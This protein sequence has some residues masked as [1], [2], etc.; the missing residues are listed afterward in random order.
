MPALIAS[1]AFASAGRSSPPRSASAVSQAR[2]PGSGD[3]V[4]KVFSRGNSLASASTTRLIRK[5][6]KLIPTRP[7]WQF[8]IE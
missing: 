1:A 4:A 8:E 3:N 5:S 6:P 7:F 2:N